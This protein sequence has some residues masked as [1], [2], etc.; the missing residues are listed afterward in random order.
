E[1]IESSAFRFCTALESVTILGDIKT[2][3]NVAFGS[4]TALTMVDLRHQTSNPIANDNGIFMDSTSITTIYANNGLQFGWSAFNVSSEPGETKAN[5]YVIG[6]KSAG[7]TYFAEMLD[8]NNSNALIG[9]IFYYDESKTVDGSW[10]YD[11]NG[12]P[13]PLDETKYY[14]TTAY[15][16][17]TYYGETTE[18][19][20]PEPEPEPD[21][22]PEV[23]EPIAYSYANG[24]YTVT[25]LNDT[26]L[27]DV[28]IPAT[29][30]DG[31][32][33]EANVV[34]IASGAFADN[35]TVIS[36][37]ITSN[38]SA[39][40][41]SGTAFNNC[42]ALTTITINAP[43]FITMETNA[44]IN[45]PALTTLICGNR[46][47][48][49]DQGVL[50]NLS[51]YPEAAKQVDV[52][53][54]T[55]YGTESQA[56][57]WN[58]TADGTTFGGNNMISN[59]AYFYSETE[60]AGGWRYVDGVATP[61][62]ANSY[63]TKNTTAWSFDEP[64][65]LAVEPLTYTYTDGGYTVTGLND[66]SVTNVVIPATYNDG[67]N[68]EANVVAI[69]ANAFSGNT[70]I[71]SV[72]ITSQITINSQ[73]FMGCT[74]LTT[75]TIVA[76]D[77]ITWSGDMQFYNCKSLRT[78]ICGNRFTIADRVF[79]ANCN[80]GAYP[81]AYQSMNVYVSTAYG[82]DSQ[83]VNWDSTGNTDMNGANNLVSNKVYFY[84]E[85]EVAGGWRYVDGVAT[86]WDV[87][88]Y[89]TKNTTAWSFDAPTA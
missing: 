68:G 49:P 84:S 50:A 39:F 51:V 1:V 16:V 37:S 15:W 21:P 55:A 42:S 87:D 85:T 26:S 77:F 20:D 22:E 31:T 82:A 48:L 66:T 38:T 54:L 18:V 60:V 56:I 44:I 32:N 8:A 23:T 3:G 80:E 62:D 34:G 76:S 24:G 72:T 45:C 36:V 69:A 2:W 14:A 4:C 10:Y 27:T 41:I 79:F 71:T 65:P 74:A 75:V 83:A 29:Y 64:T 73:A 53:V 46:F 78:L 57:N 67:T 81:E 6:A 89:Y 33:G 30:D 13:T 35:S 59:K 11:E 17:N 63:Y 43:D 52:Y 58:L 47:T 61:W 40:T 86:A 19:P 5:V 88:S 25:G 28:V 7:E 70:T 12:N 9:K